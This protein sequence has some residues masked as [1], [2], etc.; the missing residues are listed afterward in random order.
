MLD[1]SKTKMKFFS[2]KQFGLLIAAALLLDLFLSSSKQNPFL[3]CTSNTPDGN[4]RLLLP[5]YSEE[6]I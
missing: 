6:N 2:S 4:L 5:E 1:T 3:A